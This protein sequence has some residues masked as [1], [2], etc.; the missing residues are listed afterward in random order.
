VTDDPVP[1]PEAAGLEASP[2]EAAG[3][4]PGALEA[5]HPLV[6][7]WLRAEGVAAFVGGIAAWVWLG[8]NPV[9]LIALI[10]TPDLAMLG[11]LRGPAVGALTYNVVHSWATAGVLSVRAWP[12][13][14]RLSSSSGCCSWRTRG[15]TVA[16]ATA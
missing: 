6:R 13:S 1:D 5:A 4:T 2:L 16:S 9:L 14:P 3:L 12:S 15:W 10:L 11:Y 8:G 7:P